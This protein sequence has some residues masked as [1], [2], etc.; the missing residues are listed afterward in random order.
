MGPSSID[1]AESE[2]LVF[3]EKDKTFHI[4]VDCCFRFLG[5]QI[6]VTR[7]VQMQIF[8]LNMF[9]QVQISFIGLFKC[10]YSVEQVCSSA[11]I[12]LSRF[13]RV[14]DLPGLLAAALQSQP[15]RRNG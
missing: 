8:G 5:V 4:C 9:L 1:K 15:W 6:F 3:C 2:T 7:F 10:K 12:L 13:V 11:N 14:H